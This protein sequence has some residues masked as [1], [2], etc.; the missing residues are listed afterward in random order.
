MV[1]TSLDSI[2]M[3]ELVRGYQEAGY[4]DW[5]SPVC[6]SVAAESEC[7]H[8]GHVGLNFRGF[9][10]PCGRR[11]GSKDMI[12]VAIAVCPKCGHQEEF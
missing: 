10:Y 4:E 1:N 2:Y 9:Q 12:R 6:A 5:K 3:D 8:C 7:V 11:D